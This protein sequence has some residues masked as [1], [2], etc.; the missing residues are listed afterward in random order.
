MVISISLL[1]KDTIDFMNASTVVVLFLCNS[2]F[3]PVN[4][5]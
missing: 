1:R 3:C 5:L 4:I 2:Y